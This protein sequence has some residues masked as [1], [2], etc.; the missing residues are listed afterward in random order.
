[1]E[2]KSTDTTLKVIYVQLNYEKAYKMTMQCD[3]VARQNCWVSIEKVE[4]SFSLR[5]NKI[6]PTI[7][8]IQLP[9]ILFW[10]WP[11]HKKEGTSLDEGVISFNL[12]WQYLFNQGQMYVAVIQISSIEKIFLVRNYKSIP[13]IQSKRTH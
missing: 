5:N 2:F 6:R 13:V 9:L 8:R 4:T 11:V 3:T 7:K 10:V 12:Q 1:M